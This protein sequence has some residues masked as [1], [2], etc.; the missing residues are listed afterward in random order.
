MYAQALQGDIAPFCGFFAGGE[1]GC[2]AVRLE[3]TKRLKRIADE[4]QCE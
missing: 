3:R 2:Q 1:T 4:K